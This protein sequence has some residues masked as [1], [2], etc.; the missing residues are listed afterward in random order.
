LS[1]NGTIGSEG[2][3]IIIEEEKTKTKKLKN[4]KIE[5]TKELNVISLH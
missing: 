5:G 4:D 1:K 2:M 3:R